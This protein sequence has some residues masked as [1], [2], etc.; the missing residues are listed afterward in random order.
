MASNRRASPGPFRWDVVNRDHLGQLLR[1]LPE[2]NLWYLDELV[3]CAAQVVARSAG[4]RLVFVGRSADSIFDLLSG[5]FAGGAWA[6]R[7]VR[8]PFSF[9]GDARELSA[10]EVRAARALLA[11]VGSTPALAGTAEPITFV[12][13][14]HQ[15]YTFANLYRLLRA[16]TQEQDCAWASVRRK[17]RFVGI[18]IRKHTSP[19]TWRWQQH[20]SWTSELSARSVVN[21]SLGEQVWCWL[22][23]D[24]PKLTRS[25]RPDS[26]VL[27]DTDGPKHDDLTRRA[28]AESVAL[29][30][31]G[32]S[33]D[34]RRALARAMMTEPSHVRPWLRTVVAQLRRSEP[35]SYTPRRNRAR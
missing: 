14:V 6:E 16:W 19:K 11:T 17:L 12:D 15:G 32:S 4:S 21:V 3:T 1:G 35:F 22:G 24:Q 10:R 20:A 26:W 8:L 5:A 31:Y 30:T 9:R 2:P 23:N 27:P 28:L 33:R 18:T 34:G 29:V 25:F 7:I 13:L